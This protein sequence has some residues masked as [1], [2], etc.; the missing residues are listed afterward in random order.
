MQLLRRGGGVREI[1]GQKSLVPILLA[2]MATSSFAQT[3][4]NPADW[5]VTTTYTGNAKTINWIRDWET[6]LPRRYEFSNPVQYGVHSS[7]NYHNITGQ[8]TEA[9]SASGTAT[10]KIVWNG[11][12]PSP[13][14]VYVKV[15]SYASSHAPGAALNPG[16][17]LVQ[18]TGDPEYGDVHIGMELRELTVSDGYATFS[19]SGSASGSITHDPSPPLFSS[20]GSAAFSSNLVV[21]DKRLTINNSI[22]PTYYRGMST[23]PAT[24]GQG[25]PVAHE[26]T[27]FSNREMTTAITTRFTQGD[28][29][30]GTPAELMGQHSYLHTGVLGG[31]WS[32]VADL[33]VHWSDFLTSFSA[34]ASLQDT[35]EGREEQPYKSVWKSVV[36]NL[37]GAAVGQAFEGF[38]VNTVRLEVTDP[39]FP[40][41]RAAE[42]KQNLKAPVTIEFERDST[43]ERYTVLGGPYVVV[44]PGETITVGVQHERSISETKGGSFEVGGGVEAEIK[45]TLMGLLEVVRSF[46][47]STTYTD[48]VVS[49]ISY[50]TPGTPDRYYLCERE[51][52]NYQVFINGRY[53]ENGYSH[54]FKSRDLTGIELHVVL[55]SE[56]TKDNPRAG[57]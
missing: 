34:N 35:S 44:E 2:M 37:N 48:T 57:W 23:D 36:S 56:R 28:P 38:L 16:L 29:I 7:V 39:N 10:H 19:V 27:D 52:R 17:R 1:M 14:K 53:S 5:T 54:D 24:M 15:T 42:M 8:I 33:G 55:V 3:S 18:I 22:E 51:D 50:T 47:W 9:I 31:N 26:T 43:A 20:G 45:P 32:P 25:V 41:M 6:G 11:Q 49:Q 21:L 30:G 40:G 46:D 13:A 4:Y 12:G